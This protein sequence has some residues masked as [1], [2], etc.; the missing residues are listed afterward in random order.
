MSRTRTLILGAA[1]GLAALAAGAGTAAADTLVAAAPG[2]R[3]LAV[4][5]GWYAWAAPAPEGRWRLVLRDPSRGLVF[6][7]GI[8]DFG[9]LPDPVIGSDVTG[10]NL[11]DRRL[12]VGYARCEGASTIS[13]CDV[14]AYDVAA[15]REERVRGLSSSRYSETAPSVD[16]GTWSFVRRGSGVERKGV[17]VRTRSDRTRRLSTVLARE[18]STNGSRVAYAYN[19]NAGGGVALRRASGDGGVDVLTRRRKVIPSSLVTTRY[20]AAWL[21]GDNPF[22][23][24]RFG[25][26]GGPKTPEVVPQ[27]R[28]LPD[29][30]NS[31]ATNGSVVFR[32]LD[33]R[34]VVSI[35]PPLFP[36]T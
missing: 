23:T 29:T 34:G 35:D 14:W 15:G 11:G 36:T 32:Y 4:G 26:S 28:P 1:C 17:F 16:L 27:A 25:G 10:S 33:A 5:G 2:A 30:V 13:G 24:T 31:I 12:V 6:V 7:P 8:P 9:G 18:T 21:E 3:N 22:Q 20:R 19:S